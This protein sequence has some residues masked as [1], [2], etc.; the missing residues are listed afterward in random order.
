MPLLARAARRSATA[1]AAAVILV[2]GALVVTPGTSFAQS[3]YASSGTSPGL[4]WGRA[5]WHNDSSSERRLEACDEGE[6]DGLRTIATLRVD[7]IVHTTHAA[8]GTGT[9]DIRTIS[10]LRAGASYTLTA[11]LRNGANGSNVYCSG[12]ARGIIW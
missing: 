9:C 12:A 5:I 8:R 2:A 1:V 10:G 7:G 11:C 4:G 3:G 6:P